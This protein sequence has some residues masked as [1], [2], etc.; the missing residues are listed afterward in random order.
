MADVELLPLPS[1]RATVRF[2]G[3]CLL[4]ALAAKLAA[5]RQVR[6]GMLRNR[7]G[8][9]H[10]YWVRGGHR[11]EFY[12]PGASGCSYLRN[13]LRLGTVRQIGGPRPAAAVSVLSE[14]TSA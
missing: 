6:I 2:P 12:T 3:N 10:F 11:F 5:P 14:R 8:R 9:L 13:A 1:A 4:V 7:A